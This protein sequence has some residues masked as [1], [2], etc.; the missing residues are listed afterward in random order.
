MILRIALLIVTLPLF[1]HG[2][3]SLYHA[4]RSQTQA[5]VSCQLF[6]STPPTTGWLRLT[7]CEIDYVRAGYREIRGR[8]TELFIPIRPIG[9]SPA[10]PSGLVLSTRDPNLLSIVERGLTGPAQKDREAFLLMMLKI[11]TAMGLSSEIEGFTRPPL[12]MLR[13][14]RGLSAI[15]APLDERF[16]VLDLGARPRLLFPMIESLVGAAG[17]FVL[18]FRSRARRRL[19]RTPSSD[20]SSRTVMPGQTPPP[21]VEPKRSETPLR[22]LMLVNLPPPASPS[23]L[24]GAPPLGTQ[25]AVRLA[26]SKVLPGITFDAAG[27]GQF[28][29]PDHS[30]RLELGV[31]PDVWT[32]TLEVTGDAAT[33]ALRRLITQTGWQVY[34]PLL[35]RFVTSEDL[36]K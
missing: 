32:A 4:A 12:E 27:V 26:L 13:T 3:D 9:S 7:G 18:L 16:T 6:Q 15:K 25:A 2:A 8:V 17:L 30:M 10:Q 36:R 21:A 19:D 11:V 1:A 14:R 28:S 33:A 24:E 20:V 23:A 35:G 22:H 29:R 5:S 34:A 31:A